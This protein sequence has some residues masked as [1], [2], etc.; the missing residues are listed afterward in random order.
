ML[1]PHMRRA[2]LQ[3]CGTERGRLRRAPGGLSASWPP[4][5][6]TLRWGGSLVPA[7]GQRG[8]HLDHLRLGVLEVQQ[9]RYQPVQDLL[10]ESLAVFL[11]EL[12]QV[13]EE[14]DGRLAEVG[15]LLQAGGEQGSG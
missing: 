15:L 4:Q 11:A 5:A 7:G 12:G 6:G 2:N 13:A 9:Q 8:A 14:H 10:E 3:A 1:G